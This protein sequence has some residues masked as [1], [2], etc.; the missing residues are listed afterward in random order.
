[1]KMGFNGLAKSIYIGSHRQK[2]SQSLLFLLVKALLYFMIRSVFR[3]PFASRIAHKSIV[4]WSTIQ[5][6]DTLVLTYQYVR[7]PTGATNVKTITIRGI[8]CHFVDI[9]RE[10]VVWKYSCNGT[11]GTHT[12]VPV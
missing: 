6:A 11:G 2:L 7:I 12:H 3:P 4:E 10:L 9:T 1:M 8:T 5:N